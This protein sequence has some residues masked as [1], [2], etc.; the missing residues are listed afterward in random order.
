MNPHDGAR[1]F[2][3]IGGGEMQIPVIAEAKALGLKVIC[4]DLNPHCACVPHADL[5]FPLDIFDIDAHV[6]AAR[7]LIAQ[8]LRIAGVLAAGIDA[9]ETMAAIAHALALP[10]VDPAIARLVHDKHAFREKLQSLGFPVPKFASVTAGELDQLP[11][12]AADIGYPLIIKNTDSSGSRGTRIFH[13][14]DDTA[15][16]ETAREAIAV[17]ASGRALI[18]SFWSGPEQTVETLFDIDGRFHP[19][20]ITDR[21]FDKRQGYALETGL[22]HPSSL[23][24]TVQETM[25]AIAKAVAT[26]IGIRIGAAKYD[27]I[28]TPEG[29]RIIEMTVRLSGG[30]D[31]QYLV[32][33][34]TG[35]NVIRA[36]IL[37]AIGERFPET[38][39]QPRWNKAGV[40]RSLWPAQGKITAIRNLDAA[41]AIEGVEH[42]VLRKQEGDLVEAYTDC[43][44]RVCFIIATATDSEKANAVIHAVEQTLLIETANS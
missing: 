40:S 33:R 20:F 8:G 21:L 1:Y 24:D 10:G 14:P 28:L 3:V 7:D 12:I 15:L 31:C 43:T 26:A 35:K 16:R 39:L 38:L 42:I 25:Y 18:E 11:A 9:P 6:Q 23:P 44:K 22:N 17:S 19:C 29:P 32:P 37:T 27:F 13:A 41:R 30:F 2:W 5:F 36:A 34:T 4:S